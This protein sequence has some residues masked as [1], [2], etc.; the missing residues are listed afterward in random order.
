MARSATG[1][2]GTY[3]GHYKDFGCQLYDTAIAGSRWPVNPAPGLSHCKS[4][5]GL[6]RVAMTVGKGKSF[7]EPQ[8]RSARADRWSLMGT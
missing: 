1:V 2:N 3:A 7:L 4:V 8:T 6:S 5:R